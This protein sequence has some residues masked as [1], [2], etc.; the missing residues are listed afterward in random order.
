MQQPDA[1]QEICLVQSMQGEC[2]PNAGAVPADDSLE[3]LVA[4]SVTGGII[5]QTTNGNVEIIVTHD[6]DDTT[7]PPSQVEDVLVPTSV[8]ELV[9]P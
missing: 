7:I 6:T 1:T 8:N 2:T 5:M 4:Q 9:V 3:H